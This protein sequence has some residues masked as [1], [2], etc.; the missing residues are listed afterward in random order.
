[1]FSRPSCANC[2]CEPAA[3]SHEGAYA[4]HRDG[5]LCPRH[6]A[7]RV[8]SDDGQHQH[9]ADGD[10]GDAQSPRDL[11][12]R[13]CDDPLGFDMLHGGPDEADEEGRHR[14]QGEGVH[15]AAYFR[16]HHVDEHRQAQMLIAVHCEH[17]AQHRHPDEGEGDGFV[18]PGDRPREDIA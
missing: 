4:H 8:D 1:M 11:Q 2:G 17:R 13:R 15:E 16:R 7:Q 12:C 3:Q 5:V 9:Q 18:D 10:G 14:R 6:G